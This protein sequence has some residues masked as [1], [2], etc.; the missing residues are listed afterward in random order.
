[1]VGLVEE[2]LE[3]RLGV[4]K[5]YK[6][7]GSRLPDWA[8]GV[9]PSPPIGVSRGDVRG[10]PGGRPEAYFGP[11]EPGKAGSRFAPEL[12]ELTGEP[13][14]PEDGAAPVERDAAPDRV[15]TE[16][17]AAEG[18]AK[19]VAAAPRARRSPRPVPQPAEPAAHAPPWDP[20]QWTRAKAAAIATAV[21]EEARAF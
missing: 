7:F 20:A 18:A 1:D 8:L 11:F 15:A 19:S 17:A 16:P 5:R 12:D 21:D 13:P 6:D 14:E 9:D 4:L 3:N 10:R 2:R